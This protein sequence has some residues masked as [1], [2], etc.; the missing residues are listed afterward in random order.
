MLRER[1]PIEVTAGSKQPVNAFRSPS[2]MYAITG[3]DNRSFAQCRNG[4][5]G[6]TN[7]M[8]IGS[9]GRP[10]DRWRL[11]ASCL[12]LRTFSNHRTSNMELTQAH[13]S[14]FRA[15]STQG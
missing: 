10:S 4:P 15:A 7:Q 13:S 5:P 14:A 3:E 9:M 8:K 1:S 11:R 6:A 2:A 12:D